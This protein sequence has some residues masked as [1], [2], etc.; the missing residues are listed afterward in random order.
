MDFIT[1]RCEIRVYYNHHYIIES[2]DRIM[3]V[4]VTK[5]TNHFYTH[6]R[7][8]HGF[9]CNYDGPCIEHNNTYSKE[10]KNL[11][12]MDFMNRSLYLL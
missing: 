12:W 7:W 8:T 6:K 1:L 11:P 5:N 3:Y 4:S 10:K 2:S 9:K